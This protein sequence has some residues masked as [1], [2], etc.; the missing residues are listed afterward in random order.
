MRKNH[1]KIVCIKLVHLPYLY[2]IY[3]K[4]IIVKLFASSWYIFLTYI[5]YMR[6][7]HSKVVCIKLV[8]LPY[9]YCIHSFSILSDD[10]SKAS[11]KTMPPHSA[12][13]YMRKNHSKIV[14]IKLVHLPYFHNQITAD[15]Q[16]LIAL[17]AV[18]IAPGSQ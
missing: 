3:E 4:K 10:R 5:V 2:C 14:C 1:S 15:S 6:K 17:I 13:V 16:Q 7:N 11:S 12:I 8:H 18:I 9:L